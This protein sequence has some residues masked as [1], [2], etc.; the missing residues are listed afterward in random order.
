MEV[1]IGGIK[2]VEYAKKMIGKTVQMT[3]KVPFE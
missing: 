2:D 1:E 3:F